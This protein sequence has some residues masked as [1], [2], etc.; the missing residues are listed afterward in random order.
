MK[1]ILNFKEDIEQM[2]KRRNLPAVSELD[3]DFAIRGGK[4][5]SVNVSFYVGDTLVSVKW[6]DHFGRYKDAHGAE[7]MDWRDMLE[8]ELDGLF[9]V[10]DE[11][12]EEIAEANLDGLYFEKVV[13]GVFVEVVFEGKDTYMITLKKQDGKSKFSS[14]DDDDIRNDFC[15]REYFDARR[16]VEER[17]E[18]V[19][20]RTG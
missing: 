10:T 14:T 16:R 11:L 19:L 15:V 6:D 4:L 3:A 8:R 5:T 9:H 13:G 12:Y 17:R 20:R 1:T 7:D 18:Y 2:A